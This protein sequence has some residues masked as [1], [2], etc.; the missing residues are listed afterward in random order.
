[1]LLSTLMGF[2]RDGATAPES[3]ENAV[4]KARDPGNATLAARMFSLAGRPPL[5]YDLGDI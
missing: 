3:L 4:S 5:C 2:E 1:M